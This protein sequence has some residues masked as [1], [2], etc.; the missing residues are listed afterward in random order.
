MFRF[1]TA[2]T[3]MDIHRRFCPGFTIWCNAEVIGSRRALEMA[4]SSPKEE[5]VVKELQELMSLETELQMKW[6]SLKRAGKGMRASFVSSLRELQTRT[7]Q[8][9]RLLDSSQQRVA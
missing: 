9:E 7:Q 3:I 1:E 5:L 2:N 6:K 8:L 4:M